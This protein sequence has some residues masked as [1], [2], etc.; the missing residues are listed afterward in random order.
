MAGMQFSSN[1]KEVMKALF[2]FLAGFSMSH[3]YLLQKKIGMWKTRLF[4]F[5][6]TKRYQKIVDLTSNLFNVFQ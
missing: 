5:K 3:I 4:L 2:P 6:F 1:G